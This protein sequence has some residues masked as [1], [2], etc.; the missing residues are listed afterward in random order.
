V[1]TWWPT[2]RADRRDQRVVLTWGLGSGLVLGGLWIAEIAFN[3]LAQTYTI[4]TAITISERGLA[5][6]PRR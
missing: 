6:R 5:A 3:N 1:V 4:R 2:G